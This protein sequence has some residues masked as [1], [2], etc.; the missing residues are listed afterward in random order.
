MNG[1][2]IHSGLAVFLLFAI[3][4][5]W[6]YLLPRKFGDVHGEHYIIDSL[7]AIYQKRWKVSIMASGGELQ[8]IRLHKV[9]R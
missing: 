6:K 8:S 3:F 5:V 4:I 1:I 7:N 2:C 9:E